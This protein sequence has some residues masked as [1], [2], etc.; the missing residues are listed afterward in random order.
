M[1]EE[2]LVLIEDAQSCLE[3]RLLRPAVVLLGVAYEKAIEVVLLHFVAFGV[4]TVKAVHA[5][6]ASERT[7]TFKKLL[8]KLE[9]SHWPI[10]TKSLVAS[11][12][13]GRSQRPVA[14]TVHRAG[15]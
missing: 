3:F 6:R 13:R 4:T 8:A 9:L 2:V 11:S 15:G 12:R 14:A 7:A 5:V 1:D 10:D